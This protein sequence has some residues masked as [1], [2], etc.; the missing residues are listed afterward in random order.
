VTISSASWPL[1]QLCKVYTPSWQTSNFIGWHIGMPNFDTLLSIETS[2]YLV[3]NLP[4]GEILSRYFVLDSFVTQNF[5]SSDQPLLICVI[6][7]NLNS[8]IAPPIYIKIFIDCYGKKLYK[9]LRFDV[10]KKKSF[11]ENDR[12]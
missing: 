12:K 1:I 9:W 10:N 6:E 5:L 3:L 7:V 8:A 11:D 2:A 4:N